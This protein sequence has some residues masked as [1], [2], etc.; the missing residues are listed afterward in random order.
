M[1]EAINDSI[2]IS[3]FI[4]IIMPFQLRIQACTVTIPAYYHNFVRCSVMEN[5]RMIQEKRKKLRS[6]LEEA[7]RQQD[8]ERVV[9]V[10][11]GLSALAGEILRGHADSGR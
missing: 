3:S 1:L 2:K 7:Y 10:A 4:C 6:Q 8:E 9:D 11:K 5:M